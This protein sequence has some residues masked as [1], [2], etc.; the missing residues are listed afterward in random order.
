MTENRIGRDAEEGL[1]RDMR[2]PYSQL[3]S[4]NFHSSALRDSREGDLALVC[5]T[6]VLEKR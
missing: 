1:N 5:G 4:L 3:S 6:N 2:R